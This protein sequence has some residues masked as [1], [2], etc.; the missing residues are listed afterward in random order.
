M[1]LIADA[2]RALLRNWR[3][4]LLYIVLCALV[5]GLYRAAINHMDQIVPAAMQPKPPWYVAANLAADILLACV[6]SLFQACVYA[7]LGSDI[8]KPLWKCRDD[9]EAIVRFAKIWVMF[10][11]LNFALMQLQNTMAGRDMLAASVLIGMLALVWNLFYVPVGVC[12]MH[13]GGLKDLDLGEA[14]IP[15]LHF[16]PRTLLVAGL[17]FLQLVLFELL[18]LSVPVPMQKLPWVIASIN[19]PLIYLECLGVAIMWITCAEYRSV[20]AER[21]DDDDFDF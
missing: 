4:V 7:R 17:G 14:L 13:R 5:V 8:D 1:S 16:L 15:M 19:V 18:V 6:V 20:A 9:R 12:L 10:N 3:S 2:E 21:H 11:L